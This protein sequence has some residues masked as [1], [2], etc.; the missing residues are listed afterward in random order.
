MIIYLNFKKYYRIY[1]WNASRDIRDD[2][3][4]KFIN[5]ITNMETTSCIVYVVFRTFATVKLEYNK[6]DGLIVS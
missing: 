2:N 4:D 5:V 1:C 3:N 6:T